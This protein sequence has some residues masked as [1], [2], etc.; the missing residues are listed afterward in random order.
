LLFLHI[1]RVSV[2]CRQ[3]LLLMQYGVGRNQV[4]SLNLKQNPCISVSFSSF[5]ELDCC[6]EV[7]FDEWFVLMVFS[8]YT[9]CISCTVC[10]RKDLKSLSTMLP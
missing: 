10:L 3:F 4:G 7:M 1:G 9:A 5:V 8:V 6:F 2:S